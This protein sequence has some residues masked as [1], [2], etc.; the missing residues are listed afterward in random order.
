MDDTQL[1]LS[2]PPQ[3]EEATYMLYTAIYNNIE[4]MHTSKEIT[5]LLNQCL[6]SVMDQKR[7]NKLKINPDKTE[8]L[9][10]NQKANQGIGIAAYTRW[11]YTPHECAAWR[12]FWINLSA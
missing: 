2:F 7:M 4:Y 6:V 5:L 1:Y 9:L 12:F 11:G 3:S 10:V 8:V